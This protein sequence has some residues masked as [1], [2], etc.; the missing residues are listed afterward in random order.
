M[1]PPDKGLKMGERPA[2]NA[3][4]ARKGLADLV[5]KNEHTTAPMRRKRPAVY[6][7]RRDLIQNPIARTIRSP[8]G[9]AGAPNPSIMRVH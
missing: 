2:V 9:R 7:K 4:K 5:S 8:P 6:R 1:R 3:S